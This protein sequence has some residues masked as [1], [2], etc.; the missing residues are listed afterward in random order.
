[1][2]DGAHYKVVVESKQAE[3]EMPPPV[4]IAAS[5]M[6]A[7]MVIRSRDVSAD[8]RFRRWTQK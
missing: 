3:Q 2:I 1:L 5:V 4:T 7:F 6:S 8:A